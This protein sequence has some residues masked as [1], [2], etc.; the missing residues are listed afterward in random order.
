MVTLLNKTSLY[1]AFG[2]N[3]F[4]ALEN[5]IQTMAPSMVEYYLSDLSQYTEEFYLNKRNVEKSICIGEYSIYYDYDEN[6]C[7]E[8]EQTD[9]MDTQSL[10]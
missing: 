5:I 3:D 2:V 1:T 9:D 6:I 4:D 7:L 10:W 8:F